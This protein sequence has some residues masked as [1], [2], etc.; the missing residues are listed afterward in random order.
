MVKDTNILKL[1]YIYNLIFF[2]LIKTSCI[3]AKIVFIYRKIFEE[4]KN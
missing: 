1:T 4:T 2:D 3:F